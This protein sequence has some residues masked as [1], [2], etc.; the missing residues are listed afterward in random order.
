LFEAET[1]TEIA[2]LEAPGEDIVGCLVF[3]RDCRHLYVSAGSPTHV[4]VW[5]LGRIRAELAEIGLD[6]EQPG[7]QGSKFT[8]QA[9]E[10]A[11]GFGVP[12]SQ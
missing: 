4:H 9:D 6:W 11:T 7:G 3:S 10:G 2:T 12:D 5:D 8:I 1:G